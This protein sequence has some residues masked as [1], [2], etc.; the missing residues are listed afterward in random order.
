MAAIVHFCT[1]KF[2]YEMDCRRTRGM[3]RTGMSN[4][5]RI[6][7]SVCSV[8]E[9][10]RAGSDSSAALFPLTPALSLG[11]RGPRTPSLDHSWT[12]RFATTLP[13]GLPLPKG[14]GRGEGEGRNQPAIACE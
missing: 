12:A 10:F 6:C 11:E 3:L 8:P 5:T 1:P 2:N 4:A 13:T 14:E 9:V 7:G